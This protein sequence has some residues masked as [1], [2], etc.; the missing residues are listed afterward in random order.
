MV[1]RK[2]ACE[3]WDMK[4]RTGEGSG[5]RREN[6]SISRR[7]RAEIHQEAERVSSGLI[8]GDWWKLCDVLEEVLE[9]H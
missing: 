8:E 9:V 4:R 1:Q 2:H 5:E 6:A 7:S 3:L